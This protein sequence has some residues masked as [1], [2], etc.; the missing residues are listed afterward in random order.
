LKLPFGIDES[1]GLSHH[2]PRL[3]SD[4]S[5]FK[6][7]RQ[8][9]VEKRAKIRLPEL[10][11][12]VACDNAAPSDGKTN[13]FGVFDTIWVEQVPSAFRGFVLFA[14]LF[15]GSGKHE[16]VIEGMGT[17]GRPIGKHPKIELT[18]KPNR[19]A[20]LVTHIGP[21]PLENLG[22]IKFLIKVSGHAVGWPCEIRVRKKPQVKK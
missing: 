15:G 20:D 6:R 13:L 7:K 1:R 14:K 3:Q 2:P 16:L 9:A 21:I 11:C 4:K 8:K 18:L 17:K 12:F 10:R 19:G 5:R 22:V